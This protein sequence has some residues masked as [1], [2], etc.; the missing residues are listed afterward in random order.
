[1]GSMPKPFRVKRG[2]NEIGNYLARIRGK[3]LNLQTKDPS[4]ARRR[5]RLALAGKWPPEESA[6]SGIRAVLDSPA[7]AEE[8]L[9]PE[10]PPE[11]PAA[12]TPA[13]QAAPPIDVA[14][15]VAAAGAE[16]SGEVAPPELL[17]DLD[18]AFTSEVLAKLGVKQEIADAGATPADAG[19]FVARLRAGITRQIVDSYVQ[20]K[21]PPRHVDPSS[22][23]NPFL[24]DIEAIAWKYLIL[25]HAGALPALSP[26]WTLLG[27]AA[28]DVWL[29]SRDIRPGPAPTEP[30]NPSPAPTPPPAVS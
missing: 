7:E 23:P 10:P 4:E 15:A 20:R 1:M 2:R 6:A 27:L 12:S 9:P 19:V 28:V 8:D 17:E 16:V 5:V 11:P 26:G 24:G 22:E 29:V 30:P 14:A 13:P 21:G 3:R 25:Q 18:K